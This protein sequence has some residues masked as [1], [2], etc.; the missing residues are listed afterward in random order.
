MGGG[1]WPSESS[2]G[3]SSLM[4][5]GL[6]IQPE[7]IPQFNMCSPF[8]FC[9]FARVAAAFVWLPFVTQCNSFS[10]SAFYSSLSLWRVCLASGGADLV[11]WRMM[12]LAV[13]LAGHCLTVVHSLQPWGEG[14]TGRRRKKKKRAGGEGEREKLRGRRNRRLLWRPGIARPTLQDILDSST[15]LLHGLT[16]SAPLLSGSQCRLLLNS[17]G[18]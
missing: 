10:P 14:R 6:T 9:L 18:A 1:P 13:E 3:P 4:K 12:T 2:S 7:V 8:F 15:L 17:R 16:F 5:S 11:P